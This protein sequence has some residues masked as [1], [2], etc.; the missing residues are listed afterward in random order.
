MYLRL[1][2]ALIAISCAPL[3]ARAADEENPL[4][5]AKVGDY[6]TYKMNVKV[7]TFTLAGTTTQKVTAKSDKEATVKTTGSIEIMGNKQDIPEQTQMI[8]LTKP[9]DPT[10]VGGGSGLP[11]GVKVDVEKGKE[12][13][14]KVKVNGKEYDCTWTKYKVKGKAMGQDFNADVKAWMSKDLPLGMVK[15]EMTADVANMKME[16]NMELTESGNKK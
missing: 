1:L 11:P 16:M 13:K 12:G 6:A 14:E 4:K 3:A 10:K 9:F 8:D 5:N 15:M 7:A 2:A